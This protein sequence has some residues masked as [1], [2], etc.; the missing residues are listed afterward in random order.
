MCYFTTNTVLPLPQNLQSYYNLFLKK[1][2]KRGKKKNRAHYQQK[3]NRE[4]NKNKNSYGLKLKLENACEGAK[5]NGFGISKKVRE[6]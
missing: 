3:F 6:I 2:H 4:K 1:N 5:T